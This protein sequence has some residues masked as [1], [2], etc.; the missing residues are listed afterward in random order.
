V[1]S[2]SAHPATITVTQG[3]QDAFGYLSATWKTWLPVVIVLAAFAW[4]TSA[5]I[6]S[7]TTSGL[8]Y[9]DSYSS[10]FYWSSDSSAQ[11]G[12]LTQTTFLSSI[13]STVGSWVFLGLAVG[14]LRHQALTVSR[15]VTRGLWSIVASL[16]I[17]IVFVVAAAA[18]AI[19]TVRLGGIGVLVLFAAIPAV[20]YLAIR[21]V[22]TNLAI[23]DGFGPIAGIQESW[24]LSGGS[25]LR[26]FGWGLTAILITLGF[27]IVGS[28]AAAPFA[29]GGSRPVGSAIS[30]GVTAVGS[31]LILFMLAAL[32]ESQRARSNPNLYGPAPMYPGYGYPQQP[33]AGYGYP[34]YP[35]YPGYPAQ[36]PAGPGWANPSAP[37][38][39]YGYPAY[40]AP[41]PPAFSYPGQAQ[42]GSG[43]VVPGAPPS[44]PIYPSAP[45]GWVA[46]PTIAP[47]APGPL[48]PPQSGPP[49]PTGQSDP[50]N[51]SE[52]PAPTDPPATA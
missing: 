49:A 45:Q 37:P 35:G 46:P 38:A 14:G 9:T 5:V 39:G 6:G 40:P 28:I 18:L 52:P 26:L 51:P 24:R 7:V 19:V 17:G 1:F 13:A 41:Q 8:F 33:P 12:R 25:V 21:V 22:F 43:W 30:T 42:P 44:A 16:F 27:G 2:F 11:V 10:Q 31:C 32:Y 3:I 15:V 48:A 20:I 29:Q 47:P 36:P 4:L 50:A 34:A 23:F